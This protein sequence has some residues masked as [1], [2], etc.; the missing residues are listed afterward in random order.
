[1]VDRLKIDFKPLAFPASG[2]LALLVHDDLALPDAA[3]AALAEAAAR[4]AAIAGFKGKALASAEFVARR[5]TGLDRV[6]LVGLG[7]RAEAA[8]VNWTACRRRAA[9]RIGKAGR[10]PPRS[11]RP[12]RRSRR[13]GRRDRARRM[14]ARLQ[15]R[16]LPD[17][18]GR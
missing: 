13:P 2:D 15:V 9:G 16:P 6:V 12:T 4:A 7:P 8:K 17:E 5:R 3:P 18:E 10:S 14:A 1:M 11:S